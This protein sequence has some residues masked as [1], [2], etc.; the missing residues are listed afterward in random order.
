MITDKR[1]I[2]SGRGPE[3]TAVKKTKQSCWYKWKWWVHSDSRVSLVIFL[4]ETIW[5]SKKCVSASITERN[6]LYVKLVLYCKNCETVI[7]DNFTSPR[8]ESTNNR[9]A[10]FVGNRKAVESTSDIQNI[11]FGF[12][13]TRII[14]SVML[15]TACF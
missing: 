12:K 1:K 15:I 10:A 2:D 4:K 13:L 11:T 5:S 14:K 8:M 9:Q 7:R 6:V 3:K